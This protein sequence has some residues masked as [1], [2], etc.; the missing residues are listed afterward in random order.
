MRERER[1]SDFRVKK[2]YIELIALYV[3]PKISN[4]RRSHLRAIMALDHLTI[5]SR[6]SV[7]NCFIIVI[8]AAERAILEFITF[9]LNA[10]HLTRLDCATFYQN[11]LRDEQLK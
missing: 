6:V 10:L 3:H 5:S 11:A 7:R 9:K 1:L 2:S 4:L 8:V